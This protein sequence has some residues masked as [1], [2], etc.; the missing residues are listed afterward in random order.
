MGES[1]KRGR[2]DVDMGRN[3]SVFSSRFARTNRSF[4]L[5]RYAS[6]YAKHWVREAIWEVTLQQL[7][8]FLR[9]LLWSGIPAWHTDEVGVLKKLQRQRKHI[10]AVRNMID[11]WLTGYNRCRTTCNVLCISYYVDHGF[12]Y[13]YIESG[14]DLLHL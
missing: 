10:F 4:L 11:S 5:S 7:D 6:N 14:S 1:V 2:W 13:L 12:P 8:L 3:W 9:S